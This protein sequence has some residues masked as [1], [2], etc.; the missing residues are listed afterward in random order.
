MLDSVGVRSTYHSP[1]IAKR[2][3]GR[4][5][6]SSRCQTSEI[7]LL[8]LFLLACEFLFSITLSGE[9]LFLNIHF[10]PYLLDAFHGC[11]K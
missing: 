5:I 1:F 3:F 4:C 2:S 9:S 6:H 8:S 10:H 7:R 11:V